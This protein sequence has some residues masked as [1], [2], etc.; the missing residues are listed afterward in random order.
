MFKFILKKHIT[1]SLEKEDATTTYSRLA[2]ESEIPYGM[3]YS[4]QSPSTI[5]GDWLAQTENLF[6]SAHVFSG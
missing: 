4:T 1:F 5:S 2:K 6:I 3:V